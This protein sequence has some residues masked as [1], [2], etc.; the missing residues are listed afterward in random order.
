METERFEALIDAIL[1]IIITIIVM[2]IPLPETSSLNSLIALYP[3]FIA[4]TLSFIACFHV[5]H[6]HH[7]LFNIVNRLNST[8]TWSS[9]ISVMFVGLLPHVTT[10]I[11]TDFN[12]FIAQAMFGLIFFITLISSFIVDELLIRIDKAN[13]ALQLALINRK[14]KTVFTIIIFII[15]Y[16]IGYFYYPPAITV[17]CALAIAVNYLPKN[18]IKKIKLPF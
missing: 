8:V 11:A 15:G 18:I 1:A 14:K 17:S 12:S 9:G 3:D 4:Y 13:I 5:W 6:Y 2:E 16:I 7:N 10:M